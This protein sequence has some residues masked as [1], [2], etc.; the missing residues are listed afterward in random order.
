MELSQ[1]INNLK[2]IQMDIKDM[3]I[4]KCE[5]TKTL[6]K[7]KIKKTKQD[8][9]NV[10]NKYKDEGF[11]LIEENNFEELQ[12]IINKL[13]NI[14]NDNKL[15]YSEINDK[16]IKLFNEEIK[17]KDE[18]MKRINDISVSRFNLNCELTFDNDRLTNKVKEFEKII[19]E[20]K[21]EI[22]TLHEQINEQ[23]K[24]INSYKQFVDMF[25]K[26]IKHET[27]E[28]KIKFNHLLKM[29]Y[30]LNPDKPLS[31]MKNK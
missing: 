24:K 6:F 15:I 28:N 1:K 25:E 18:E 2:K 19:D 11:K 5:T 27:Y 17:K 30:D 21:E 13:D 12:N 22:K 16:N 31:W 4:K 10:F 26:T 23:N 14:S 3:F 7:Y 9:E 20:N 8:Y 29:L